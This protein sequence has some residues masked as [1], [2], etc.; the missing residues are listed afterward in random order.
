MAYDYTHELYDPVSR[1]WSTDTYAIVQRY[2]TGTKVKEK[3]SGRF[4][5]VRE[6]N[7]RVATTVPKAPAGKKLVLGRLV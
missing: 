3:S 7:L 5:V 6:S 2:A 1:Q 4:F